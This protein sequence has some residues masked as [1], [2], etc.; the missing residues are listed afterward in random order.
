MDMKKPTHVDVQS[1]HEI[2]SPKNLDFFLMNSRVD[3]NI[4]PHTKIDV[5]PYAMNAH[6]ITTSIKFFY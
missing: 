3:S 6:K 5:I 1:V 2:R 4:E